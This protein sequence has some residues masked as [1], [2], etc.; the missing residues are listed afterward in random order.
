M[1]GTGNEAFERV[2][3]FGLVLNMIFYL[4]EVYHMDIVTG[5][6]V[7]FIWSAVSNGLSIFGGFVSDSYLGRFRVIAIGSI[8]SFLVSQYHIIFLST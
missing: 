7:I 1:F 3:S 2:A 6:S 5:T 8:S 4:M